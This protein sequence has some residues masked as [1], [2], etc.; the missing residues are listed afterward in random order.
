M[1]PDE[2]KPRTKRR[3]WFVV[4]SIFVA[5][6]MMGVVLDHLVLM[7]QHRIFPKDGMRAVSSHVVQVLDR[8]LGLTPEQER[9]AQEIID[10]RHRAMQATWD[11]VDPQIRAEI[12]AAEREVAAIL[13]PEQRTKFERVRKR[14]HGHA[15]HFRGHSGPKSGV[16]ASH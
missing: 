14:W 6:M 3:A 9:R 15:S 11:A 2:A 7:K 5:G 1:L 4:G 16:H 13:T 10:R 8:E 12:G